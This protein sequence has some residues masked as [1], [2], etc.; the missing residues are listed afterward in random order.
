MLPSRYLLAPGTNLP[1]KLINTVNIHEFIFSE[2]AGPGNVESLEREVYITFCCTG[3]KQLV[4]TATNK[5]SLFSVLKSK[6]KEFSF[7][8]IHSNT[9]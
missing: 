9:Q 1:V 6:T 4:K 8:T 5:G 2:I 3:K 7:Q